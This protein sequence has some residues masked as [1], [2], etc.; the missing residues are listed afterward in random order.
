MIVDSIKSAKDIADC[1]DMYLE[2]GKNDFM[3]ADRKVALS[4]ADTAARRQKFFRVIRDQDQGIIAF[5]LADFT[6]NMHS[7]LKILNQQYYASNQHGKKGYQCVK[8]LHDEL[9]EYGEL[10]KAHLIASSGS[11]LDPDN[12]FARILE[13]Q[14]WER[15]HFLS[16]W[17]T[18]HYPRASSP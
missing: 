6:C 3:L 8:L 7:N 2:L 16:I 13:K 17:K 12:V 9:I 11:H 15:R 18:S 1:V 5:L 4:R 10:H 14:G